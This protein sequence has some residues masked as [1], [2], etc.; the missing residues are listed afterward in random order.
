M[1]TWLL[2]DTLKAHFSPS[3]NAQMKPGY[4][5]NAN[6]RVRPWLPLLVHLQWKLLDADLIQKDTEEAQ[7]IEK[8]EHIQLNILI[9]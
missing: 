4:Y 7:D 1:G 5:T 6:Y 3:P 2:A 9:C 8:S